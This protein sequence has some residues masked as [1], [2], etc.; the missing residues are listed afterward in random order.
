MRLDHLLSKEHTARS[1]AF[2]FGLP[3]S[4]YVEYWPTR[5]H[6]E[7]R[8]RCTS[9]L[10]LLFGARAAGPSP[11]PPRRRV[12][13]PSLLCFEE[14]A[15]EA[16]TQSAERVPVPSSSAPD[17]AYRRR[18]DEFRLGW[19]FENC[20]ASTS[21]LEIRCRSS[22]FE[23]VFRPFECTRTVRFQ[24]MKSQ[25]WMPWRQMPMKD[26]GGC[27]K[28]R[29]AVYQALIRGYPNGETRLGSCPVTIA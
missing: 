18:R 1:E 10:P 26:V 15:S 29:G 24:A 14:V 8:P 23:R 22:V 16:L 5:R 12:V 6:V 21:V 3:G 17:H 27:E 11:A 25:R 2:V 9:Q 7:P 13:R 20:I 28:P 19:N 4:S